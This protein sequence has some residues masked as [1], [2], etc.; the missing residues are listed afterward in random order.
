MEK[1]VITAKDIEKWHKLKLQVQKLTQDERA[2]RVNICANAFS[3]VK[4]GTNAL[5]LDDKNRLVMK[6]VINRSIDEPAYKSLGPEY[7]Q[8]HGIPTTVIRW[9]PELSMTDY[10]R[11]TPEQQKAME[12]F[13]KTSIGTPQLDIDQPKRGA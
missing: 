6:Y 3:E 1:K 11:L 10:R 2:L 7:L 9:K 8:S 13:L 4:E 12:V 5:K